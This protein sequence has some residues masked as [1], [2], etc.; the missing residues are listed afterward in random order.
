MAIRVR[1]KL[2]NELKELRHALAAY[3][4]QHPAAE[5]V[6]ARRNV[7]SIDIRIIDPVFDKMSRAERHDLVWTF[8][9]GLE[10]HLQSE[11]NV[12]LLLAPGETSK[13]FASL[14]FDRHRSTQF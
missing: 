14:A 1:G 2:D 10:E 3:Q 6:V 9:E 7:A 4:A 11:V 13:S 8:F 12:L 5:V